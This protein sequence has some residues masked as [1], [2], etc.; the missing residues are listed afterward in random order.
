M[1]IAYE[2][3][4]KGILAAE[5]A[6]LAQALAHLPSEQAK[7]YE[8]VASRPFLV[9]RAAGSLGCD[10]VA[11]RDDICFP[12]EVKSAASDRI[13]LSN[14]AQLKAQA[15]AMSRESARAGVIALYAFRKKNVRGDDPWRVFCMPADGIR[16]RAK[17]LHE[18][19]PRLAR[20][21]RGNLAM[22]W[23]EGM[24]LHR[25]IDLLCG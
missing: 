18:R 17:L 8:R 24:A 21:E 19:I 22:H 11:L 5:P 14:T 12:V 2:R 23:P 4:L 9:V 16:G 15:E 6:V 1:S 20:T 3:E 25:L 7:A 13:H 10:L